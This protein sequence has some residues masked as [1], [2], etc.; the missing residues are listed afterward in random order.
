MDDA[1]ITV[2][3]HLHVWDSARLAPPWLAAVPRLDGRFLLDR[4]RREG[5]VAPAL[6][7]VEADLA[8]DDRIAEAELLASWGSAA[9][10]CAIVAGIEPGD[11]RFAAELG[12]AERSPSVRGARR[13]L[14]GGRFR[15]SDR[16]LADLRRLGEAGLAFDFCV[17]SDDLAEVARCGRSLPDL[18]IVVDH[19]GNPP[20][21]S[22]WTSP[23][24]DAW[25]EG[26]VAVAA[27][28][29]AVAKLSGLFENAGGA[30]G[31]AAARPWFAWCLRQ[32]GSGRLL[33]GSNWPVCFVDAPLAAWLETTA[34]LLDDLTPAERTAILGGNAR[35]TY[36]MAAA[37]R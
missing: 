12:R 32:F 11:G 14:H 6:V 20:I 23:A 19:L 25:R 13:V 1:S 28:P 16:F 36:R 9:T 26:I 24:A 22:G 34:D 15:A 21:R 29:Q 18:T 37:S 33:W 30:I 3:A 35:R 31:A 27:C 4:Y 17:R 5:G 8:P 10:T 7:L 2:D